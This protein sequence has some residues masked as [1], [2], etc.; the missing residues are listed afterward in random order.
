MKGNILKGEMNGDVTK[1]QDKTEGQ[2]SIKWLHVKLITGM[3]QEAEVRK[4]K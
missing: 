4:A 3:T 2:K 1:R